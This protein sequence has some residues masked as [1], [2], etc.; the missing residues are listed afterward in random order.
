M[1]PQ[2]VRFTLPSLW[3]WLYDRLA[4]IMAVPTDASPALKKVGLVFLFSIA[5]SQG[6]SSSC[7]CGFTIKLAPL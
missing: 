1:V 6:L 2:A 4:P 5:I 7:P 3:T